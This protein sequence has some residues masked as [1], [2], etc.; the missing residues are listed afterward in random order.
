MIF[1]KTFL[2]I[3][4]LVRPY[5][6]KHMRSLIISWPKLTVPRVPLIWTPRVTNTLTG[7]RV[8]L[9]GGTLL[10]DQST[11]RCPQRPCIAAGYWPY[12]NCQCSTESPVEGTNWEATNL[13][14]QNHLGATTLAKWLAKHRQGIVIFQDSTTAESRCT[15][16]ASSQET[17]EHR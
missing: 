3:Q 15:T 5:R 6:V 10:R 4:E 14:L 8:L 13:T 12:P 7:P 17:V 9:S 1:I 2:S 11:R 16:L